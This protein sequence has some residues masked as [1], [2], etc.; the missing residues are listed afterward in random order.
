MRGLL[1]IWHPSHRV[2]AQ[3]TRR[4]GVF[5]IFHRRGVRRIR[6]SNA[7]VSE[8]DCGLS[9]KTRK[10]GS[11]AQVGKKFKLKDGRIKVG[12]V[13][14]P[15]CGKFH[16]LS[17]AIES[18]H[19]AKYL[20]GKTEMI[21]ANLGNAGSPLIQISE[22]AVKHHTRSESRRGQP[23]LEEHHHQIITKRAAREFHERRSE[24]AQ[25][26]DEI[27]EARLTHDYDK[28]AKAPNKFDIIG[29]DHFPTP[30]IA[31]DFKTNAKLHAYSLEQSYNFDF[32]DIIIVP[33][34][35]NSS[36]DK[37]YGHEGASKSAY[38]FAKTFVSPS[39]AQRRE[40]HFSP[41]TT[42]AV[43]KGKITDSDTFN[44]YSSIAHEY[45]HHQGKPYDFGSAFNEGSN[46]LLATRW[47][48]NN[49][50]MDR[51]T[52]T[53]LRED[54]PHS[55]DKEVSYAG[56]I[57]LI[58]NDGDPEE[59]INWLIKVRS[60]RNWGT[61]AKGRALAK[62]AK[63][64]LREAY[65]HN[66]LPYNKKHLDELMWLTAHN[67]IGGSKAKIYDENR[68]THTVLSNEYGPSHPAVQSRSWWAYY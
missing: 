65:R 1:G 26:L 12:K 67:R 39:G 4:A 55:Y 44:A 43:L 7:E 47:T 46:E 61:Y 19:R 31:G 6:H 41:E 13:L 20:A 5:R 49:V 42:R 66:K 14:C 9:Y 36:F 59:A 8:G 24:H 48:L 23:N 30:T 16:R 60:V 27:L 28:W 33:H 58:V 51:G 32:S 56:N 21:R 45:G 68:R 10:R 18:R 37:D 54:P 34:L 25:K 52:R 64:K 22:R 29:V 35:S 2:H 3:G 17:S 11:R 53:Y 38:A 63:Q 62:D 50:Q 57:A 40:V 15:L